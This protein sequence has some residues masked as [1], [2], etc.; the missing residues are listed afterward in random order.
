MTEPPA[1]TLGM[2]D[3]FGLWANL[4]VSLLLPVAAA[5]AVL[6]GRSL[7]ASILAI[8]TGAVIGAILLGLTAAPAARERVPAMVLLRGL[9]GRRVSYVPTALNVVQCVGW[10]TF[11]IV[12]ISEAASRALSAPRWPFV[13]A[14]GLLATVMAVR[15]LGAMRVL[16][17]YAVWVALAATA[18]LFVRVLSHPLNALPH[19]G[20]VSFWTAVDVVI[21]MP[22]SWFPLA[23]DYTRHSRNARTAFVGAGVGY[24]VSTIAFFTLG[25]LALAAY[26]TGGFD[27]V[28]ALLAV[29]VGAL[30]V[31]VLVALE[32]DEVF[33]NIYSTAVST[34]NFAA[35]V[36][37]RLL[38]VAVGGV[39]TVLALVVDATSYEAFLFLIGAVFV[40]LA[41]VL[42]VA[43]YLAPRGS[44]DVSET[45]P[46]RVPL[47]VGWAA[48][49][50]AYQLTLPTYFDGV[51][52]G[53]TAWWAA[54]QANLGIPADNGW[55]ASLVSLAVASLL[56][57]AVT[58]PATLR[59][60]RRS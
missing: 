54:R 53:W 6:P 55:S 27:V 44:W 32:L 9:L 56:T 23:A 26:G 29:P 24:G 43:Y 3:T 28:G 59:A 17:R 30:A 22:I 25:L 57:A 47:I 10:A 8:V 31:L 58:V 52:A 50:V 39:A 1:Q 18:Y 46:A 11:E 14:A 60:R 37:R 15:P 48:G 7:G 38:A 16:G 51:G 2:R 5:F 21:A 40:P 49:F 42:V 34:Q 33:A 13:L 20:A 19:E 4:G 35:R 12:I 41:G 45:A 36:D